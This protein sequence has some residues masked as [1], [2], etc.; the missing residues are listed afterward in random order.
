MFLVDSHCH[1]DSLDYETVH[2]N[3]QA[4]INRACAL[5]VTHMLSVG[6]DLVEFSALYDLVKDLPGVYTEIGRAHV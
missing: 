5:G 4:V 3:V 1:L 2:P 6:V